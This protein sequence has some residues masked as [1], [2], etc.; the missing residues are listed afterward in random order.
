MKFTSHSIFA[1]LCEAYLPEASSSLDLVKN[2][3]GGQQVIQKLHTTQSLAHDQTYQPVSKISWSDLK[4]SY[5]G[6]WVII[7]GDKGIGAIRASGGTTGSYQALASTG[8][9]TRELNDSR[10]GN[11][12]D[13]LK[14]EIGGLRKFYVGKN[15][16][17]VKD[18]KQLRAKNQAGAGPVQINQDTL[19]KK[20]RP[21]WV[22][23]INASIADVKGMVGTMVKNDA[24]EKAEKKIA[25]L[26]NLESALDVIESGGDDVP[27]SIRR[28]VAAGINMAASHYYPDE[29]G[30]IS[31]SRWGSG[32]YSSERSEGP[33]KLLAD[34]SNGDTKKLGTILSFFKRSLIS[35]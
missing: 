22:R 8:G 6:A 4:G 13:F 9:E 30:E 33:Q 25:L 35:G 32:D 16:T 29:T 21:L 31:R 14:G 27:N 10:G 28:A 11:I 17:S 5:R 24:F 23:A 26:K 18:K 1:H 19:I 34:I 2:Q 15:S 7:Q 20:F 3:P 12:I